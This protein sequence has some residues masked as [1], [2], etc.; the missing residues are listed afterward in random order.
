MLEKMFAVDVRARNG[1]IYSVSNFYPKCFWKHFKYTIKIFSNHI[2]TLRSINT[3]SFPNIV[4][5]MEYFIIRKEMLK[6]QLRS[7]P[8]KLQITFRITI[9]ILCIW[10]YLRNIKNYRW[11][12]LSWF[13]SFYPSFYN[14][15][16]NICFCCLSFTN[17]FIDSKLCT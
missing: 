1:V 16:E 15:L 9:I 2:E 7:K 11:F 13:V 10:N 8:L 17:N 12:Q 14:F 3:I 5:V 4:Y 6:F